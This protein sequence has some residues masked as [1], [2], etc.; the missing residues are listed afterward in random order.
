MFG[1][2][3]FGGFGQ[4]SQ[5]QQQQQNPAGAQPAAGGLFGQPAQQ[6]QAGAAGFGTGGFGQTS[7][8]GAQPAQAG[9]GLFGQQPQQ[10]QSQPFTFGAGTNTASTAT[11]GARPAGTTGGFGGFGSSTTG[12]GTGTTGGFTFGATPTQPQQ[13]TGFGS[14]SAGGGAFG[15]GATG[16]GLFGQQPQQQA[17]TGGF[18]AF[19]QA[20]AAAG[21]QPQITQGTATVPYNPVRE[22]LSP[23]EPIKDRKTFDV[24]QSL[25]VMPAYSSYSPE[26]LRL[27]DYQ[28]GRQKGTMGPGATGATG[29]GFGFGTQGST[30]ATGFGQQPQTG[31]FG[32]AQPAQAGGLFG[33]QQ[34]QPQQQGGLFG[35]PAATGGL[36]GAK[37]G[38]GTTGFGSTATTGGLFGQQQPAQTGGLFGQQPG[39]AGQQPSTGFSFGAQNTATTATQPSTGFSFGTSGQQQLQQ[40]KPAFGF[41]ASTTQPGQSNFSFGATSQPQQQ[42]GQQA[43]TTG[44]GGTTGGFGFGASTAPKP[45]GG[46][47]FGSTAQPAGQQPGTTSTFG[48]FGASSAAGTQQNK[49]AFSF[50]TG[51]GFGATSTA[52]TGTSAAPASGGLFGQAAPATTSQPGGNLFG[53]TTAP[54]TGGFSFGSQPAG[55]TSTTGGFGGG[56]LFGAKPGGQTGTQPATGGLFGSA[57]ATGQ[58]QQQPASTG[59]GTGGG[60][61]GSSTAPKPGGFSFGG[62]GTTGGGGLFGGQQ[63]QQQQP[64]QQQPAQ[65]ATG[66]GFGLT[67]SG[68][69]VGGGGGLFGSSAQTQGTGGLFGGGSSLFGGGS[70]TTGG[71][72]LFG[73][74][75]GQQTLGQQQQQQ[76][77]TIQ[78]SLDSNPYGTDSLFASNL[79]ASGQ[80]V[81]A[82]AP[83]PFNVAPKSKPPLVAPFR[84]SPRSAAK[85]TR[86][87]GSTPSGV[88]IGGRD[89]TPGS[90]RESTP[91]SFMRFGT[92]GRAGSPSL[93]KG[94]SDEHSQPLSSQA[95]ITRPSSKR[96]VLDE[97]GDASFSSTRGG[98]PRSGSVP[99][100]EGGSPSLGSFSNGYLRSGTAQPS[101]VSFSPALEQRAEAARTAGAGDVSFGSSPVPRRGNLFSSSTNSL[102]DETPSKPVGSVKAVPRPGRDLETSFATASSADRSGAPRKGEYYLEPS[103]D[104]LRTA[105]YE[106]LAAV[107]GFIVGRQGVGKVEFL[108][109]VDL[110]TLP[111]LTDI[112]GGVVQLRLKECF[113]YPEEEDYDPRNPPDGAKRGYIPVL[114][115]EQGQGLNMPARVSLEQ[116]WPLDRATREPLKDPNHP[117]VK[118]H[119]NKLKNKAETEFVDYDPE[120]GT[121]TFKVKH[122][123][124]YGLDD[125]DE[126]DEEDDQDLPKAGGA[127]K[128]PQQA[129]KGPKQD[130]RQRDGQPAGRR[131]G[132]SKAT[133]AESDDDDAPPPSRGL[134]EDGGSEDEREGAS[135]IREDDESDIVTEDD[136]EDDDE[137]DDGSSLMHESELGSP[138][139][140]RSGQVIWNTE[141][142]TP[143]AKRATATMTGFGERSRSATPT[144]HSLTGSRQATPSA[145]GASRTAGVEPRR[146]QVMQASFF[147]Q[148]ESQ[149][150]PRNVSTAAAAVTNPR[151]HLR[152]STDRSSTQSPAAG[153]PLKVAQMDSSDSLKDAANARPTFSAPQLASRPARKLTRTDLD[154]SVVKGSEGLNMDAGLALG[155]SFRVGWGPDGTI[156]HN[157]TIVSA[158]ALASLKSISSSVESPSQ[159]LT[160]VKVEKLKIFKDEEI[161]TEEAAKA[162]RLLRVQLEQTIVERDQDGCPVAYTRFETRFHH[163]ASAFESKD[164]SFE[165]SLWRL[166]V[167]LFDEIKLDLPEE[168]AVSV[169][170]RILSLRRKT[171]L[172]NWLRHTVAGTVETEARSH[173]AASRKAALVFSYLSGNQVERACQAALEGGDLRLATLISQAGGDEETK[174]DISEQLLIWR[175]EGVDAHIDK[176]HRRIYELLSGNVTLSKG[177]ESRTTRDPIDQVQDL[178]IPAGLDWKRAFGLHLWYGLSHEASLN[179]SFERYEQ[180]VG[181]PGGTAPPL[182][183]YREGGQLGALRLKQLVQS[184]GYERDAL[185]EIIKLYAQPMHELE[186]ALNPCGFGPS[187]ADLRLPWHLY[188]L[189]SRVLRQRD[190]Q[191]RT[192]LGLD[193]AADP[194]E[195][196]TSSQGQVDAV[197]EGN[198]ARADG[199]C[200]GYANQL[201]LQGLW[202]WSIFI[203]L[204]LELTSSRSKAIKELLARK[205]NRIDGEAEAFLVE[206]LQIP[207]EWIF[208]ARAYEARK[209]D[210][211]FQEF[212]LLLKAKLYVQAHEVASKYLAPEAILRGD[213]DLVLSLFSPFYTEVL[214]QDEDLPGWK[215]G[216]QVYVDYVA[217]IRDLPKLIAESESKKGLD[218][219]GKARLERLSSRVGP[220]VALVARLLPE[221]AEDEQQ[222]RNKTTTV[223]TVAR[224]EMISGLDNLA[225]MLS[226]RSLAPELDLPFEYGALEVEGVQNAAN[227]YCNLLLLASA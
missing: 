91:G 164:R 207:R 222:E 201:E 65:G 114:K 171:A 184:G 138:P 64:Q 209:R 6:P 22:D 132:A 82:Q 129:H 214:D 199:L 134:E 144:A 15:S 159:N 127:Q 221:E 81:A 72:G 149:P 74:S 103:L 173:V 190:F 183:F 141:S 157:G 208:E 212:G 60:L 27:M 146:V 35:Q 2:S 58:Q 39:Q 219:N 135:G 96:L 119:I 68:T 210:D 125:S 174:A 37:P 158:G 215:Q 182:P 110:T 107:D 24:Q 30:T 44:F 200:S 88:G 205:V 26:E 63:T 124:R 178:Q 62:T 102:A 95:F 69:G 16:G 67:Q 13:S 186:T 137:G 162:E 109:P 112:A 43:G 40:N 195:L 94:L 152:H 9:G 196:E 213:H 51:G 172:S 104:A 80:G 41:G 14:T 227:D 116:C 97:P 33:Q 130:F 59:F 169:A 136:G 66:T 86:L 187:N 185:F 50:G 76:Q 191:D 223:R 139:P 93:F 47:L 83:L 38:G 204:H 156:V 1:S 145:F 165:A 147:G 211:R 194:M 25:V 113:V 131:A 118:Q 111:D 84:A 128:Q 168:T 61:F 122:F 179:A 151:K 12:T 78:A 100:F 79:A 175:Q 206:T 52:G 117:R 105:R 140:A 46:G 197:A 106:E 28:Q 3:S 115:A 17:A 167:A 150:S 5:Q 198:S 163:F 226:R 4:Q 181:G 120:T 166:G 75:Q 85:I 108:E 224:A 54:A 188:D 11:F 143:R 160:T 176:D 8:G 71:M 202:K 203:L 161:T 216:G 57:G 189:L 34:Q 133:I 155:R 19:G 23:N 10:Q 36:F 153:A 148:Q 142:S 218:E 49:P 193:A 180:V 45:A 42:A 32:T 92:P 90:F 21:G 56:G 220:L 225:R 7:F 73:Q 87:R 121:W 48:G 89:G 77:P 55:Q 70:A 192:D 123:S 126:E 99:A 29:T 53:S 170:D 177:T 217:A 18:G 20:G 31:A 101:R 154:Q 98:L